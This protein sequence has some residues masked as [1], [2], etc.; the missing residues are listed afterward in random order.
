MPFACVG[1]WNHGAGNRLQCMNGC[2][3]GC[4]TNHCWDRNELV[5]A[6]FLSRYDSL[7]H[8]HHSPRAH[9]NMN[10]TDVKPE[11]LSREGEKTISIGSASK[12]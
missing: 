1:F 4:C 11:A 2:L 6:H 7:H 10:Y 12:K 5:F 9:E 3:L 8:V